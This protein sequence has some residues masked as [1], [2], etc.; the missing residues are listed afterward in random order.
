MWG[1][2][3]SSMVF[4]CWVLLGAQAGVGFGRDGDWLVRQT[5][6]W[7]SRILRHVTPARPPPPSLRRVGSY[8]SAAG[9]VTWG[10]GGP[11]GGPTLRPSKG[12]CH[13]GAGCRPADAAAGLRWRGPAG[14]AH[15]PSQTKAWKVA[16]PV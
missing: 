10:R 3:T 5:P 6:S 12:L 8:P 13:R 4:G 15:S 16:M 1:D 7:Q 11:P 9:D 2:C 14:P